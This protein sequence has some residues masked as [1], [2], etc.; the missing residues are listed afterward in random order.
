[1]WQG[2]EY[3]RGRKKGLDKTWR[4]RCISNSL[5]GYRLKIPNAKN[6]ALH[7]T[8]HITTEWAEFHETTAHQLQGAG[9]ETK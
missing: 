4:C 5:L 2:Q 8:V 7:Y 3:L 6:H 9:I 1:M